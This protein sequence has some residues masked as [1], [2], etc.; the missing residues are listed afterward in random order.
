MC[1]CKLAN[2]H[3]SLLF[4]Q[5]CQASTPR[6]PSTCTRGCW[7]RTSWPTSTRRAPPSCAPRSAAPWPPSFRQ[8]NGQ[9]N[10]SA[11]RGQIA[12]NVTI[13]SNSSS[14]AHCP[15]QT[16]IAYSQTYS[17]KLC[18]HHV[19]CVCMQCYGFGGANFSWWPEDARR[20]GRQACN[21]TLLRACTRIGIV[22]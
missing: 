3:S 14:G 17:L 21:H 2:C 15:W 6:P 4:S 13:P 7:R 20:V 11:M 10:R 5:R 8:P 12:K 1:V 9:C 16:V 18:D 22:R 19:R